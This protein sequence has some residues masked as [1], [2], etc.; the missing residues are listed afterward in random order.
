MTDADLNGPGTPSPPRRP[1]IRLGQRSDAPLYGQVKAAIKR[2]IASGRLR[3]GQRL[4]TLRQLSK[5][6]GIA[7]ATVARGMRDLVEE[8]VLEAKAGR[9]TRVAPRRTSR[10]GTIGVLGSDTYRKVV[11][12]SRYFT[13]LLHLLQDHIVACG[14]TVVYRRWPADQPL[15]DMFNS[16]QLV[17]GLLL[18]GTGSHL[19][20]RVDAAR[21]L[22]V[23]I[24]AAGESFEHWDLPTVDSTNVKDAF[25]AI[26]ALRKAGHERIALLTSVEPHRTQHVRRTEG[27][28][29][30]MADNGTNPEGMIFNDPGRWAARLLG[31]DPPPTAVLIDGVSQFMPLYERLRGTAIE[32]G[33][34]LTVCAWDE[35]LWNIITPLE[36]EHLRI[37]QPLERIAE[38]AVSELLRALEDV[39]YQ[40]GAIEFP[41]TLVKVGPDGT[42]Q[43]L[44]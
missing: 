19:A 24:I 31:M 27:Y 2:Q 9:G 15:T 39:T 20:E 43:R 14:Q 38:T 4:P 13:R 18:F 6:L 8:G 36:I 10:L 23:P 26:R 35:N 34:G 25:R 44:P 11:H 3:P 30:A 22:G 29:L 33:N 40:P 37:D 32:P 12:E 7:Y 41:S 17:D 5:D 21:R 16:L 42:A 28:R 1:S